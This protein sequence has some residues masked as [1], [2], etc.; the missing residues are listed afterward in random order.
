MLYNTKNCSLLTLSNIW[1]YKNTKSTTFRK[2]DL[3]PSSGEQW[4]TSTL[5]SQFERTTFNNCMCCDL[6]CFLQYQT[7]DMVRKPCNPEL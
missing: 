3:F 2:W 5:L 7:M 1:H 6:W 4:E